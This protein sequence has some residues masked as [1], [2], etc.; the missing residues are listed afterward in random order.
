M[1]VDF[2]SEYAFVPQHL[3]DRSQVRTVGYQMRSERMPE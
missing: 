3:L 1:G 2:S